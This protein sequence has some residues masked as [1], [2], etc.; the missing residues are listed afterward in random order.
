MIGAGPAGVAAALQA[1]AAGDDVTLMERERDIGGQLRLAG[2]A[3]AH[4]EL[5]ERYRRSTLARL[6]AAGVVA[7][8]GVAADGDVAADFDVVVLASGA[9]PYRPPMPEDTP[10][11]VR[12]AWDAIRRPRRR[13]RPRPR[14]GLGR[15]VTDLTRPSSCPAPASR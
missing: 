10:F 5:W 9:R 1:A 8:L 12:E 15:R 2:L 6:H 14:S 11:A 13:R 3:P 7:Q 4:M